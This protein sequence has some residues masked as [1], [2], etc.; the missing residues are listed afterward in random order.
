MVG[1]ICCDISHDNLVLHECKIMCLVTSIQRTLCNLYKMLY[2]TLFSVSYIKKE[3][4]IQV[5]KHIYS[6]ASA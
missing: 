6:A 4:K 3:P 5:H 1:K 2:L